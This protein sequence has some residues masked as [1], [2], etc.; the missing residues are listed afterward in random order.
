M[1]LDIWEEK[2]NEED[3]FLYFEEAA[4]CKLSRL[5]RSSFH[6]WKEM[7]PKNWRRDAF[8]PKVWPLYPSE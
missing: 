8:R 3:F 5:M 6:S 2:D 1:G 4:I 7:T